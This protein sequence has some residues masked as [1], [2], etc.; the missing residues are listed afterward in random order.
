MTI[1]TV[2]QYIWE[3]AQMLIQQSMICGKYHRNT[4]YLLR[5][6]DAGT[7]EFTGMG[8][9]VNDRQTRQT[10]ELQLMRY[11][12]VRTSPSHKRITQNKMT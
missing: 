10:D 12:W 4:G 9:R 8:N 7:Q 6:I 1:N 11:G 3:D 5:N 2:T